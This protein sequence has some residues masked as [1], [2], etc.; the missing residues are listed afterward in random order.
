[1]I[2]N[3]SEPSWSELFARRLVKRGYP[4][5][6]ANEL[7][8]GRIA[9]CYTNQRIGPLRAAD[10]HADRYPASPRKGLTRKDEL[11][12]RYSNA[13]REWVEAER[14][15][16]DKRGLA[17]MRARFEREALYLA[18]SDEPQDIV[19]AAEELAQASAAHAHNATR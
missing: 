17:E 11:R 6:R 5:E 16:G 19:W 7:S 15:L 13:R 2:N 8:R 10:D 14:V 4:E 3:D 1:M 9:E 18:T 12:N